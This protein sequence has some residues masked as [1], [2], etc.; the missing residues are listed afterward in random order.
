MG[1]EDKISPEEHL[2]SIKK[3]LKGKTLGRL[4]IFLGMAA[5]VGKT[6]TMLKEASLLKQE[7]IDP[8]IG[9]IC[10]HGRKET[11]KMVEGF[12]ILPPLKIEYLGKTF[13]ELDLDAVLKL[14]PDLVLIDEL[15]H[16]NIPGARHPKRWQ[17]VEE[18]LD[19][20]IDVYTTLNVQHIESLKDTVQ[21]I[22]DI[23][24]RETVP[25]LILERASAIQLV[26]LTPEELLQRLREG[27][28]YL[29]EQSKLAIDHF[30]KID[31]LTAL[32]EMALRFTAEKVDKDLQDLEG[33]SGRFEHW[34]PR[35]R[36]LV[37]VSEDISSQ[38]LLRAGRRIAYNLSA[39]WLAVY[40]D[41]G[42]KLAPKDQEL[43][44]NNL[45]LARELG[46]EVLTLSDESIVN[47]I[48]RIAKQRGVSHIIVGRPAK[49]G[50][51]E[52]IFK[53][54][55][56]DKLAN[57]CPGID[58]HVIR[59]E[60]IAVRTKKL[61][62]P[63]FN[64]EAA[65][66]LGAILVSLLLTMSV[67]FTLP[68]I[69]EKVAA[70]FFFL[71]MLFLSLFVRKG[72]L[73]FASIITALFWTF[74]I[75]EPIDSFEINLNE[76]RLILILYFLT[77]VSAGILID[78]MKTHQAMLEKRETTLQT[79]YDITRLLSEDNINESTLRL[80]EDRVGKV[81]KGE[82][83][84]LLKEGYDHFK[85]IDK[86]SFQMDEKE[87]NAALW[88]LENGKES[89]FSTTTLPL[90]KNLY[91]PI[92]SSQ[93]VIGVLCFSRNE[94][95]P[96]TTQEKN[97]LFAI[98]DPLY[99]ALDAFEKKT[100]QQKIFSSIISEEK[101]LLPTTS[102]LSDKKIAINFESLPNN[103]IVTAAKMK[104]SLIA[105]SKS[106]INLAPL[107]KDAINPFLK[108]FANHPI[109]YKILPPLKASID[110]TLFKTLLEALFE[111]AL[112]RSKENSPIEVKGIMSRNMLEVS[113]KDQGNPPSKDPFLE[114]PLRMAYEIARLL[115]GNL[116]YEEEKT[117]VRFSFLLPIR[118]E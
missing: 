66:Y 10:T 114:P 82:C 34:K 87:K 48:E 38:R 63:Y 106:E 49:E 28:V 51:I 104:G 110:P 86:S 30:F 33:E 9:V 54:S 67:Y 19:Q 108:R 45:K 64:F 20:G 56:F 77:I 42:S 23:S 37:A 80:V 90:S 95:E 29:G 5:G 75:I 47:G 17:D 7:G 40:I 55:L 97:F 117:G 84:L 36:L 3:K 53:T 68:Y 79:L 65:P 92:K 18:I 13:D 26:D 103:R 15:A 32:R 96:L 6:F 78:R 59:H 85:C 27:K 44:E 35:E 21:S 52:R 107:I 16:S 31:R 93:K 61:I 94:R 41:Q 71:G 73:F 24:I 12:T 101:P 22:V 69:G 4:K 116:I 113:V 76:D 70:F 98:L 118:S 8:V 60:G 115:D 112:L 99:R 43:L 11:E 111:N 14:H 39:P 1:N 74:L 83:V 50:I 105:I 102:S 81:L 46:A 57:K 100:S 2:I 25:D 109:D 89:G 72:P 58:V 62:S 88:A 91:L